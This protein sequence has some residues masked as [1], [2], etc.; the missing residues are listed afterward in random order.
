MAL[1]APHPTPTTK[2]AY[3]RG[4]G[5]L[6][7][8]YVGGC[9]DFGGLQ[10]DMRAPQGLGTLKIGYGITAGRILAKVLEMAIF[11]PKIAHTTPIYRQCL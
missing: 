4:S 11:A 10:V 2:W 6:P 5:T 7:S 8:P 3:G 1:A 9:K